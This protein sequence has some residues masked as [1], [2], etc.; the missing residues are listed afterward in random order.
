[1]AIT[2]SAGRSAEEIVLECRC[3]FIAPGVD[4]VAVDRVYEEVGM[5]SARKGNWEREVKVGVWV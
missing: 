1:M 5:A 4:D 2:G 3:E